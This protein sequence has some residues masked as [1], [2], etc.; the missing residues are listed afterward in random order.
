VTRKA[1][2]SRRQFLTAAFRERDVAL[3]ETGTASALPGDPAQ[4]ELDERH[5]FGWED[6]SQTGRKSTA[7]ETAPRIPDWD[8]GIDRVLEEMENLKGIEDF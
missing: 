3:S 5:S 7:P 1:N 4:R 2:I 8:E 6:E